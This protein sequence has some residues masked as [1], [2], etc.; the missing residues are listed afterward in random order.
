[1]LFKSGETPVVLTAKEI[2]NNASSARRAGQE[3]KEV[4]EEK[5]EENLIPVLEAIPEEEVDD[6]VYGKYERYVASELLLRYER[7]KAY[8]DGTSSRKVAI[9][10]DQLNDIEDDL[11]DP[12]EKNAF[13]EDV[14]KLKDAGIVDYSY[15]SDDA[16]EI[17]RIWLIIDEQSI[18]MAYRRAGRRPK[19]DKIKD[20][21]R[22]IDT[23][24]AAMLPDSRYLKFL[25]DQKEQIEEKMD[26]TRYFSEDMKQNAGLLR[27]LLFLDSNEEEKSEQM[28]R[29]LSARLFN[30]SRYFENEIRS[31]AIAIL[32]QIKK[33]YEG[34]LMGRKNMALTT[35]EG[36]QLLAEK[37]IVRF[38]ELFEFCGN[39][40]VM[41]EDNKSADFSA[42]TYGAC[43]NASM[44]ERVVS[45][46]F[47][48]VK[49]LIF[50]ESKAVYEAYILGKRKT[51]ELVIYHGDFVSPAKRN[52]FACIAKEAVRN[53]LPVSFRGNIDAG[54]FRAFVMLKK[55]C[56]DI[57]P[58]EMGV[59]TLQM[60]SQYTSE[61]E[62]GRETERLKVLME[63]DT[64]IPFRA[65]MLYM[66][67]KKVYLEQ[68]NIPP[69]E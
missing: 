27:F 25:K 48:G 60:Y 63:D 54:G 12:A 52:W 61:L 5:T 14:G 10:V 46:T 38:P 4:P 50:I 59:K 1:M 20:L 57:E 19:K 21:L 16:N 15:D 40:T 58:I 62:E 18:K 24:C 44:A 37:G 67:E 56:P 28:E 49:S 2:K 29:V 51:K 35:D 39:I 69:A 53:E 41:F 42:L 64:Y 26:Y 3:K 65:V 66:L 8:R 23:A 68:D 13:R 6:T 43:I 45:V 7:S 32:Y 36:E 17:D 33:D 22:F 55:F 31:Q 11:D 34:G 47:R 30:D 9:R